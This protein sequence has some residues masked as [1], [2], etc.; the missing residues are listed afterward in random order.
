MN[1][2]VREAKANTWNG[3]LAAHRVPDFDKCPR[4]PEECIGKELMGRQHSTG[5]D[6]RLPQGLHGLVLS[7][8][9]RPRTDQPVYL[10]RMLMSRRWSSEPVVVEHVLA[11]DRLEK[12]FP[13]LVVCSRRVDR[14]VVVGSARG[15]RIHVAR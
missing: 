12:S 7:S 15:A 6:P 10:F 2:G 4:L 3:H 11:T 13:L 1:G 14:A 5:R 8:L 9:D